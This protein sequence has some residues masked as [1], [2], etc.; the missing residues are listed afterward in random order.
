[1]CRILRKIDLRLIPMAMIMVS[2][3]LFHLVAWTEQR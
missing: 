1:M 3:Y 2:G